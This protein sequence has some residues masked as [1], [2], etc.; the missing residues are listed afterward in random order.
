MMSADTALNL[1]WQTDCSRGDLEFVVDYKRKVSRRVVQDRECKR[2][3]SLWNTHEVLAHQQWAAFLAET[4]EGPLS[5][6]YLAPVM[7]V[8]HAHTLLAPLSLFLCPLP[9]PIFR[10]FVLSQL[11]QPGARIV[12]PDSLLANRQPERHANR[13]RVALG[14]GKGGVTVWMRHKYR[15]RL[16]K[17]TEEVLSLHLWPHI[18]VFLTLFRFQQHQGLIVVVITQRA[19][20]QLAALADI[21]WSWWQKGILCHFC[22]HERRTHICTFLLLVTRFCVLEQRSLNVFSECVCTPKNTKLRKSSSCFIT[23]QSV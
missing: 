23:S 2:L 22:L 19:G 9:S 7:I 11:F 20:A 6:C 5:A 3:A 17:E 10:G 15:K 14:E 16:L 18:H 13:A 21:F 12:L 1:F 8:T 4:P